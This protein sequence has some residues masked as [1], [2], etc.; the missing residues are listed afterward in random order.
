MYASFTLG[1][2]NTSTGTKRSSYAISGPQGS[3]GR[4][5]HE[6]HRAVAPALP[7]SW[8]GCGRGRE[9]G[10]LLS[11]PTGP[12]RLRGRGRPDRRAHPRDPG[13]VGFERGGTPQEDPRPTGPS[14][15]AQERRPAGGVGLAAGCPQE[16]GRLAVQGRPLERQASACLS[17]ITATAATDPAIPAAGHTGNSV[18]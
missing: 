12:V 2:V 18:A 4:W 14:R 3:A 10:A 1:G 7:G 9:V 17:I 11:Q 16:Q 8:L 15:L 5:G 6:S 13:H